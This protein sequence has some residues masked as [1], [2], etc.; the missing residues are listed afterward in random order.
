MGAAATGSDKPSGQATGAAKA[1]IDGAIRRAFIPCQKQTLP[2][3]DARD[4]KV[5]M[6]VALNRDGSLSGISGITVVNSD[7]DLKIYE[8]RMKDVAQNAVRSCTPVRG[9]PAEYFDS[10]RRFTYTFD[11][12]RG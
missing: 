5:R 4:I 3:P 1:S 12:S 11:P 2:S 7:P 10:W 9:L 6:T 8:Q